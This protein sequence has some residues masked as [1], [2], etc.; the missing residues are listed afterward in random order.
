M[1]FNIVDIKVKSIILYIYLYRTKVNK[2]N[3]KKY[4]YAL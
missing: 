1:P 4:I 2:L 3:K